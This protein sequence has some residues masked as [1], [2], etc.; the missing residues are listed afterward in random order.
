LATCAA[1]LS[2]RHHARAD[3]PV[4]ESV[5]GGWRNSVMPPEKR[6]YEHAGNRLEVEYQFARDG[7]LT[8]G[9][10]SVRP[11]GF[12][13]GW[14]TFEREGARHRLH[15]LCAGDRVWVQGDQGDV[16]LRAVPRLPEA[17][18]SGAVHGGLLAPMPGQV[19]SVNVKP[20]E[21]VAAGALLVVLE[22]MK[23]EH[24]VLAPSAGRISEVMAKP[25]QQVQGGDLLVVFEDE[26]DA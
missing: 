13:D 12:A 17:G 14:V 6:T 16:V 21:A 18:S 23:M 25:G 22:A 24:Q 15:V 11:L 8:I 3:A 10:A 2:A 1:A 9:G 5:P 7:H 19:L 26:E 20:G 4:L